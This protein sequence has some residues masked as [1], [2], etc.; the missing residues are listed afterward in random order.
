MQLRDYQQQ[1]VDALRG[2]FAAGKRAPL[3][4]LPTGGG[5]TVI[6]SY[7]TQSA[8]ARQNRV[9]I[10]VHRR[11]LVQQTSETL[12]SL[13]V[14]HGVIAAGK[15][16][17]EE[18]VQ[19]ASVQ[20]LVKRL[21]KISEEP[22]LIIIDEAHHAVAGSWAKIIDHFTEAKLLGV[23]ATPMRLDGR[24]LRG[25]FDQLVI[26]P[27]VKELIE[28][29]HL[30]PV[31]CF[32]IPRKL[33][34]RAI[35]ISGG[36]FKAGQ[37]AQALIE[38]N[39]DAVVEYKRHCPGKPAIVFCCTIAHAEFVA[40]LF[41][42]AGYRSEHLS[43]RLDHATRKKRVEQ[44]GN[45]ELDILTS[46]N[47]ISEGTDI[48]VVTAAILL[49]PTESEALYLQQVGRALRPA[50]GK[51]RAIIIDCVGNVHR[52][53]LPDAN[54]EFSLEDTKKSTD[55]A[56]PIRECPRCY[57]ILP[58]ATQICPACGHIF[59][60]EQQEEQDTKYKSVAVVD[61]VEVTAQETRKTQKLSYQVRR[62][63]KRRIAMARTF[64]ELDA[65][66]KE[67]GYK[68]GWTYMIM[69]ERQPKP[70]PPVKPRGQDWTQLLSTAGIPEPPGYSDACK[71]ADET[72]A[73]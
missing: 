50:P 71:M 5:K 31:R 28:R 30:A 54:R 65:L 38:F 53:G 51:E 55:E 52:H 10:L 26:G 25:F 6:F 9:M 64:E 41:R 17:T 7:I 34:R 72:Q 3:L 1:A 35:G 15:L 32:S 43:C 14:S 33:N 13:G 24:G 39:G 62:D 69:K 27:S 63:R 42:E 68:P 40:D 66:R 57:A 23:T 59:K 12:E 61:L 22:T 16:M 48:P 58:A 56:P 60:Q 67:F 18:P 45:G 70:R 2:A 44:L 49:R 46:C 21:H 11:E 36:D 19:I 4:C 29:G 73:L 20:T 47:V 8:V 37:A